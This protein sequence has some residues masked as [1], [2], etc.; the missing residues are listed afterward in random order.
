MSRK[1][2][3]CSYMHSTFGAHPSLLL[4]VSHPNDAGPSW[5]FFVILEHMKLEWRKKKK[6]RREGGGRS[7]G[8][9]WL[10]TYACRRKM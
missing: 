6:K 10:V 8:R 3:I 7:R 2:M 1:V 5:R 9:V 4:S